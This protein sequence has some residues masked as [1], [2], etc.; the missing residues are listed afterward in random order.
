[1]S[2]TL[3]L[4]DRTIRLQLWDT[5]GQERFR[6]LIPSYIR[7]AAVTV[8]VYDVCQRTSFASVDQWIADVKE[9]RGD[10]MDEVIVV[11]VGNKADA[12]EEER[13]VSTAEGEEKARQLGVKIFMETSAKS[14]LNVKG[15]F[16]RVAGALPVIE[17][18][19]AAD[20]ASKGASQLIDVRLSGE[21]AQSQQ[22]CAC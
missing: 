20:S 22:R 3:Y 16:M 4:E 19:Q 15:L 12:S 18:P 21:P 5:A 8:I 2:K 7:D 10:S 9:E 6:T 14:G 11:L 1:M 17:P 13:Q